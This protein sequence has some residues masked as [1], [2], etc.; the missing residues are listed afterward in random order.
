MHSRLTIT[1]DNV[2]SAIRL[3]RG[4]ME[5]FPMMISPTVRHAMRDQQVMTQVNARTATIQTVGMLT[6]LMTTQV[7]ANRA[8]RLQTITGP[9]NVQTVTVRPRGAIRFTIIKD[10]RIVDPAIQR[11]P[12][13][14]TVNA[15]IAT[16]PRRGN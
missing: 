11:H 5:P 6:C 13:I 16:A 15:Q 2:L 8:T 4:L 14:R 12:V 9:A 1:M 7:I 3:T 10:R